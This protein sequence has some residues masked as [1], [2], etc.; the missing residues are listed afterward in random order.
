MIFTLYLL[1]IGKWKMFCLKVNELQ[2]IELMG[3]DHDFIS[4]P[5]P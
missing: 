2:N 1:E 5:F 4:F 3:F